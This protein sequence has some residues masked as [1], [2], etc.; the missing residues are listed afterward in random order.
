MINRMLFFWAV[1]GAGYLFAYY[2]LTPAI[3]A[4][5]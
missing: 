4:L 1:T 3:E 2:V 5:R